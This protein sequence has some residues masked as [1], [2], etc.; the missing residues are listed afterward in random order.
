M[1]DELSSVKKKD[2]SC[3]VFNG[4]RYLRSFYISELQKRCSI[5]LFRRKDFPTSKSYRKRTESFLALASPEPKRSPGFFESV[6]F[7]RSPKALLTVAPFLQSKLDS[8]D[9]KAKL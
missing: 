7:L 5:A 8:I 9:Q 1:R 6:A 3:R 2:F 4:L